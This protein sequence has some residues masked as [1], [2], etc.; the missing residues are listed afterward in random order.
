GVRA[1]HEALQLVE[2]ARDGRTVGPGRSRG[3]RPAV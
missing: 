3:S 1:R 2:R